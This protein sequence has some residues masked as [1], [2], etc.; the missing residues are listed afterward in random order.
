MRSYDLIVD[1][2]KNQQL[3]RQIIHL[4]MD[5]FYASVEM[6]DNPALKGTPVIV[7]GSSKRGVV[8]A[9]SYEARTFG[10]HSAM[11]MAHAVRLCPNGNFLPVRMARYQEI[12]DRI[13]S[14]YHRFTPL[15]EPLSLDEAFLDVTGSATLFGEAA[16]L[17]GKIR[18]IVF[19]ETGLTVS[20][21]VASS[22]L[23][24]KIASDCNKPDG[25]TTVPAG[26]E[27][28]FLAPLAIGKL[29]GVGKTSRNNLK[30]LGVQTIG[31]LR[32]LS[33]DL[34]ER[35][36]GKHGGS[37]YLAARGID[38]RPVQPARASKSIGQEETF[39]NDLLDPADIHRQ[40]LDLADKVARRLRRHGATGRTI[41][42]KVTYSDFV[43]I[44][45]SKTLATP[46]DDG[47]EIFHNSKQLL[48]KTAAGNRPVRLLGI[49]LSQLQGAEEGYQIPLFA[50]HTDMMK[51]RQIN[52]AIDTI[53]TRFGQTAIM[54]CKLLPPKQ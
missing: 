45:R 7:G 26:R 39:M 54:P 40:L 4:D 11:P 28:E 47:Q 46:T 44:T 23:V 5:A 51:R 18:K 14:I 49:S 20:A 30:M 21:G 17:A 37:L 31:D 52:R 19:R 41:T 10:I 38:N 34:L 53:Q 27:N 48:G 35:R 3:P 8:S 2:N 36:F 1:V 33:K 25:L 16:D 22:K 13:F 15:V 6:L 9:A 32:R 24:A 50:E 12:S 29:W 43:K 42:L